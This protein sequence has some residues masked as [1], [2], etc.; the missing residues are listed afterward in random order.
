MTGSRTIRIVITTITVVFILIGLLF[1][2]KPA[3]ADFA[4]KSNID[5]SS[6]I[7]LVIAVPLL[8]SVAANM[9]YEVLSR[10]LDQAER[11][12]A[13]IRVANDI[14]PQVG[15]VVREARTSVRVLATNGEFIVEP[16]RYLLKQSKGATVTLCLSHPQSDWIDNETILRSLCMRSTRQTIAANLDNSLRR[17]APYISAADAEEQ[18]KPKRLEVYLHKM[19]PTA[20]IVMVDDRYLRLTPAFAFRSRLSFEHMDFLS[21]TDLAE[22]EN[23]FEE[24]CRASVPAQEYLGPLMTEDIGIRTPR[25]GS[26]MQTKDSLNLLHKKRHLARIWAGLWRWMGGTRNSR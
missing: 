26:D 11:H 17:L 15:R 8:V 2:L 23:V 22:F 18:G 3:V 9:A 13:D 6:F 16:L 20:T 24:Y 7:V 19:V 12:V 5:T 21:N 14:D 1:F 10:Y 25:S 4:G